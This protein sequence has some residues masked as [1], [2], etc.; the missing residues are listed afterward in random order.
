MEDINIIYEQLK[1][2]VESNALQPID[3]GIYIRLAEAINELRGKGY[4]GLDLKVR[5]YLLGML[6]DIARLMLSI[7]IEKVRASKDI[8]EIDYSL[9]TD[10]ELY[11]ALEER[12]LRHRY[13]LLLSSIMNGRSK[14][15]ESLREK[16]NAVTTLV[17]FLKHVD[18]FTASD[19][20]KYGP[21]NPEDV[22][23]VPFKDALLLIKQ[24]AAVE[25]PI[26][27]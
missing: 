26:L 14:V 7:R 12:E 20:R 19:N 24:G 4:E 5:D 10:E 25:L 22:A 13:E 15:L 3:K 2:E 9:L 18:A 8:Q 6:T 23:V 17:R 11:I 16:V 1:R 27:N 21:F